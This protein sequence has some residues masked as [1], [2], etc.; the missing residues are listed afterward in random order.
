MLKAMRFV[1]LVLV[2]AAC[3]WLV[4]ITLREPTQQTT[5][6]RVLANFPVWSS[7]VAGMQDFFR[8]ID[9]WASDRMHYRQQFI[10][11]FN[12]ARLMMGWSPLHNVVVGKQGWLF[13]NS[14]AS[15]EHEDAMG[16]GQFTAE[17]LQHWHDYLV[18]RNRE[19]REQGGMFLFVVPPNKSTVYTEYWPD[20]Y[21]KVSKQT[22]LQQLV[23]VMQG[24]GVAV[25][26]LRAA[27]QDGKKL[28]QLYLHADTHW[29]LLGA[30]IAQYEIM[31]R[32]RKY[33]PSMEP[34]LYPFHNASQKELEQLHHPSD[35]YRMMGLFRDDP[36]PQVPVVEGIG[37]CIGQPNPDGWRGWPL[38]VGDCSRRTESLAVKHWDFLEGDQRNYL[39]SATEYPAG[40]HTLLMVRDSYYE[41][42]VPYFSNRF[43][44]V[45]YVGLG[46][47]IEKEAWTWML[48][49]TKPDVV[50]EE[51]LERSLKSSVPRPGIDFVAEKTP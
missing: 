4:V 5:E 21:S 15:G 24:S 17:E 35:L 8:G 10:T 27:M 19:V 36:G 33:F 11:W 48:Q 42:L 25:I 3:G 1:F 40:Q 45:E 18:Y 51:M 9:S 29:N 44:H 43:A 20:F 50:I 6:E 31:K 22:R 37:A 7:S 49:A 41:M 16:S 38:A 28:G 39:F 23:D 47:P 30:N 46:R 2:L 34:K 12:T 14:D 32:L 26:D 13:F